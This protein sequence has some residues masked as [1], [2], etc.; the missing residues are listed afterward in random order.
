[1]TRLVVDH[2]LQD[3]SAGSPTQAAERALALGCAAARGADR[4]G[5]ARRWDGGGR[6]RGPVRGAGA[7]RRGAA[8][9]ARAHA[10]RS[11]RDGVARAGARVRWAVDSGDGGVRTP[12]WGRPLLG[13]ARGTRRADVCG[14]GDRTVGRPAQRRPRVHASAVC[15]TRCCRCSKTCSAVAW[16]RR[17]PAPPISCARTA[18]VLD[19]YAADLLGRPAR[20]A[21]ATGDNDRPAPGTIAILAT[22]PPALRRRAVRAW[23][24]DQGVTGLTND[25]FTGDRRAGERLARAGR[26]GGRRRAEGPQVGRDARTWHA[27]G[28]EHSRAL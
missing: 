3:G 2:R 17:W 1:M 20:T 13:R 5:R 18:T 24:A 28:A 11:G 23:L 12:P 16:P 27:G 10:R 7:A 6:A 8:G 14:P 19:V 26:G 21:V 4:R 9:P 15:A 25:A 22:A